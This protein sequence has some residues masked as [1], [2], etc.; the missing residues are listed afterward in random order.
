M[1]DVPEYNISSDNILFN[2]LSIKNTMLKRQNKYD[3]LRWLA[4]SS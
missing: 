2:Y 1:G 4:S 3:G